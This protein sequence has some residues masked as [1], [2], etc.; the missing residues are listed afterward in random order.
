MVISITGISI[1]I[2]ASPTKMP[3]LTK[4]K[5]WQGIRDC[6]GWRSSNLMC[7]PLTSLSSVSSWTLSTLK[8]NAIQAEANN[9]LIESTTNSCL[10]GKGLMGWS[11][12]RAQTKLPTKF[13][14]IWKTLVKREAIR[15]RKARISLRCLS[16]AKASGKTPPKTTSQTCRHKLTKASSCRMQA[17]M[18]KTVNRLLKRNR[19]IIK[20]VN[21][22]N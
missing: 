6:K 20:L 16:S 5:I 9:V 21:M 4:A 3:I 18:T 14:L 15:A 22:R 1:R 10:K 19:K 12:R 13:V 7:P 17:R 11:I 2:Q 8:A